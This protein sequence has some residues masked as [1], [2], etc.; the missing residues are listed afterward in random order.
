M[1][2]VERGRG[3][4]GRGPEPQRSFTAEPLSAK[5]LLLAALAKDNGLKLGPGAGSS[6]RRAMHQRAR[7]KALAARVHRRAVQ[8]ALA[9]VHHRAVQTRSLHL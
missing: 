2:A 3:A 6:A 8:R 1:V 4:K 9:R 5:A 7:D